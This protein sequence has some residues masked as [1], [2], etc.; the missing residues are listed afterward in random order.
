[1]QVL[2]NHAQASTT[3][4]YVRGPET[5]RMYEK[6]I[7]SLQ[8]RMIGW[9]VMRPGVQGVERN[10]DGQIESD[11]EGMAEAFSHICINPMAGRAPGSAQGL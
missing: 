1:A 5:Q 8:H 3:D 9:I 11:D 7:A 4:L 10:I 2:L 6:T